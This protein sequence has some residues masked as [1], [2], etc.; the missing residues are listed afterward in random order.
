MI[1]PAE[2]RFRAMLAHLPNTPVLR[3][4]SHENGLVFWGRSDARA[5]FGR[6]SANKHANEQMT[7]FAYGL[8]TCYHVPMNESE[9][10]DMPFDDDGTTVENLGEALDDTLT[11][12]GPYKILAKLGEGGFGVVYEAQQEKPV[13][14][15][16]ALK[17]IKPGMDSKKVI[18]RF[19]AERQA[20]ALMTHT[21][22]TKVLGGG[23]TDRG[24]P[25]FV[26]ELVKGEPIT[27]FC[28]RNKMT[29]DDR[30][31]LLIPVCHAVQHAHAKAVIHRDL[32]PSNILVGYNAEGQAVPT[33][34]DFGVSKALHQQLTE[35]TIFTQEGQMIGTPEYM[36]PE[37]AEMSGLDIDT[38][39]DVYSLGVVLYELLTGMLPFDSSE[40]RGKMY[41]ELQRLIREQVPP[42]PSNRLSSALSTMKMRGTAVEAAK[43]RHMSESELPKHLRGELDW[44]VMKCLEKDRDRRYTTPIALAEELEHYLNNEPVLARPPSASYRFN[45]LVKRNR[46]AFAAAGLFAAVLLIATG[47]SVRYSIIAE[48][49]RAKTLLALDDRDLALEAE[50]EQRL[51]ADK[52]RAEETKR[53]DELEQVATFQSE[54]LGNFDP[55]SMGLSLRYGLRDKLTALA[56]R[57]GLDEAGTEAMLDEYES[58]VSGADFTGLALD[59]LDKHIFGPSLEAI[60]SQFEDQPLVEA[61]LLMALGETVRE[62]GLLDQASKPFTRALQIRRRTLGDEHPDTLASIS[63]IGYL[64]D[65]QGELSEAEPYYREALKGFHRVLGDKHPDTLRTTN[66]MGHLLQSQGKLSEAEPYLREALESSRHVLGNEHP[67]TLKMISGMGILLQSQGKLS[68]AEPYLR[69]SMEA[70]RRIHG[71]DH[72]DTLIS[73]NSMGFLLEAQGQMLKAESYLREALEGYRRVL[74]NDHPSTLLSINNMG[75][76]LQSQGKLSEAE[77]YYRESLEGHRRVLGD[78]HPDTLISINNMGNLLQSQGKLSEAE[79]YFR[80]ALESFRR[81]SGNDHPNTLTL[82]NNMGVL[83]ETQGKSHEAEPYYHE[84]LENR[85]RVLGGDHPDTLSSINNMGYLL[86]RQ[87]K[88]SEAEPYFRE[89]LDRF[90]RTLGNDHPN[91]LVSIGNMGTLLQSQGKLA[92]AES[93]YI[94]A[95]ENNRHAFGDDHP[96]TINSINNIGVLLYSQGKLSEAEPYFYEALEGRRRVLGDDHPDTLVSINNMGTLLDKQGRWSESEE[97]RRLLV[98]TARRAEPNGGARLGS[99]LVQLG[100]NLIAQ[101]RFAD[102]EPVLAECLEIRRRAMGEGHWLVWNT[103]SLFGETLAKQSKFVEAEG[104]LVEAANQINPPEQFRVLRLGQAIQ[105][106]IDLYTAWHESDP[107]AGHDT[108]AA[109]W[110]AKLDALTVESEPATP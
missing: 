38:R 76:L 32:K 62:A 88:L 39:T 54:Q 55:D 53:A 58:M 105:R 25:Y 93:L 79:P 22:I 9:T 47:V 100:I 5:R 24:L 94:E 73:I 31:K 15:R 56:E 16:V 40:L 92:E 78:D 12:I 8:W 29:L 67:D 77:P 108:K 13:K 41:A 59:A 19:E 10:R 21:N 50:R 48:R 74:G 64:L 75:N 96:N 2:W 23:L 72:P 104:V 28:D 3:N 102:A 52:A 103:Q 69:E 6:F 80:K 109:Q 81:I 70:R 84:A 87:G 43:K 20:L 86:F 95:L 17:V 45:K 7:F 85:R 26:M 66:N 11:Q 89:A 42:R 35:K 27:E 14:R 97:L 36:S 83:L 4:H 57:R 110:Q 82:I 46:G 90:R 60:E 44:V 101:N 71:D 30:L 91:T 1:C 61:R 68:E 65:A 51:V 33:V 18:A 99:T 63:N 34:I 106:V 98:G 107:A 49:E 37:Q